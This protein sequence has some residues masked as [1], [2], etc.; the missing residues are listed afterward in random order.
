VDVLLDVTCSYE[1][2]LSFDLVCNSIRRLCMLL[3]ECCYMPESRQR[4]AT[5]MCLILI[6]G[7]V[8]KEN[9]SFSTKLLFG[10]SYIDKFCVH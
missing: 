6:Y 8:S 7:L 5:V 4:F 1:C 3:L 10:F 2:D 9:S